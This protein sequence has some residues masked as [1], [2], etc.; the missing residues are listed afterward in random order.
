M[1]VLT[2]IAAALAFAGGEAAK[3]AIGEGIKDAYS[4]VK[5]FLSRKY[6]QVDLALVQNAPK[7]KARQLVPVEDLTNSGAATDAEFLPLA[8]RLL[9]AVAAEV[10]KTG[11]QTG[12]QLD[13]FEAASLRIDDVITSGM[14]VLIEHGWIVGGDAEITDN[15]AGVAEDEN[16][17]M[18][19]RKAEEDQQ[20]EEARREALEERHRAE[21]ARLAL[22]E[23]LR[24][25][26]SRQAL[27]ERE[28]AELALQA[29]EEKRQA[30]A[31][32]LAEEEKQ[33]AEAVLLAEEEKRQAEAARLAEEE[34]RAEW[35][36]EAA[37][38]EL[39]AEAD[40]HAAWER[41]RAEVARREE[42]ERNAEAARR[43]E[44]PKQ[45]AEGFF[46]PVI[47][48]KTSYSPPAEAPEQTTLKPVR[49]P[50]RTK[51]I[52]KTIVRRRRVRSCG[53]RRTVCGL[54]AGSASRC[55]SGTQVL[56][57]RRYNRGFRVKALRK[58]LRW[59]SLL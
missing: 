48:Y 11:V 54:G 59:R 43:A 52:Q 36:R 42:E 53:T 50:R 1:E 31:A 8:K 49:R 47:W 21:A 20:A 55:G 35:M 56:R 13:D 7:S 15:R 51:T 3:A 27:S 6:P 12:V 5:D 28:R 19:R 22:E 57:L 58:F 24:T 17:E 23:A 16:A 39:Q 41:R 29:G 9:D 45:R 40:R 32:R 33:R 14:G 37:H 30:E 25:E 38:H 2:V 34:K 26:A 44:E 4:A 18:A 10:R 46:G